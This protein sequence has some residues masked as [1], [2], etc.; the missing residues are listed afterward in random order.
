VSKPPEIWALIAT[1]PGVRRICE[2]KEQ[3]ISKNDYL[4]NV[5]TLTGSAEIT[6]SEK[7]SMS[8]LRVSKSDLIMRVPSAGS[9][10]S[11]SV[12]FVPKLMRKLKIEGTIIW[13]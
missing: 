5:K 11:N 10:V 12:F 3:G 8:C 7:P 9:A 13:Y 4:T 2:S 1:P 6:A